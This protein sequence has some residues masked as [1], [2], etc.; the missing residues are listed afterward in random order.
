MYD[1]RALAGVPLVLSRE[2]DQTPAQDK[3]LFQCFTEDLL[4]RGPPAE[5][6]H[7]I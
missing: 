1:A 6:Q 5:S 2:R 7:P 4:L 3:P